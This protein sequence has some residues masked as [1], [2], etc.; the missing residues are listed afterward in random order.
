[1]AASGLRAMVGVKRVIDYAVKVRGFPPSLAEP[2]SLSR[3]VGAS[4]VCS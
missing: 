3:H 4:D 2:A 1:M